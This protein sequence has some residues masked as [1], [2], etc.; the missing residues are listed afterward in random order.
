MRE[1]FPSCKSSL[2]TTIC[3]PSRH[4]GFAEC[5]KEKGDGRGT[6]SAWPRVFSTENVARPNHKHLCRIGAG[7]GG[8][9]GL[10]EGCRYGRS[11]CRDSAR[12]ATAGAK[13]STM[14]LSLT[15]ARVCF[16]NA[17]MHDSQMRASSL[18]HADLHLIVA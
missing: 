15:L 3:L 5:A 7:A 6:E 12:A 2:H 18:A 4:K 8:N 10:F 1:F 9:C 14:V 13:A 17:F 16:K 11:C